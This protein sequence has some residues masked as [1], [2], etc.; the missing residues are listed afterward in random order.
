MG[1]TGTAWVPAPLSP[2]RAGCVAA[3]VV[4]K[5]AVEAGGVACEL[6]GARVSCAQQHAL[7]GWAGTRAGFCA[8]FFAW[9]QHAWVAAGTGFCAGCAQH[10]PGGSA[11]NRALPRTR[12]RVKKL[13]T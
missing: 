6:A 9:P 10:Q 3:G 8:G 2:E 7:G 11:S 1:Q 13:I 12:S 5:E 4:R